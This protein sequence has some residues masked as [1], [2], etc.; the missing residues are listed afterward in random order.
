[1]KKMQFSGLLLSMLTT[2]ACSHYALADTANSVA[3]QSGGTTQTAG[4]P[5]TFVGLCGVAGDG[6]GARYTVDTLGNEWRTQYSEGWIYGPTKIPVIEPSTITSLACNLADVQYA[7]ASDS[8]GAVYVAYGNTYYDHWNQ[9]GKPSG[10]PITAIAAATGAK[11]IYVGDKNGNVYSTEAGNPSAKWQLNG[12]FSGKEGIT[13]MAI[14]GVVTGGQVPYLLVAANNINSY[15]VFELP[16]DTS[17]RWSATTGAS[18]PAFTLLA[19][20]VGSPYAY[21]SD[22]SSRTWVYNLSK[23]FASWTELP[24]LR[25]TQISA[26]FSTFDNQYVYLADKSGNTWVRNNDGK[27]EAWTALPQIPSKLAVIGITATSW[28]MV[29][30]INGNTYRRKEGDTT[31]A[32]E[33][34]GTPSITPSQTSGNH[35]RQ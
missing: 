29:E 5:D 16:T 26:M 21:G 8:S 17:N 10:E 27:T 12:V 22:G 9:F 18:L 34:I 15:T 19:A 3:P 13:A 20:S 25:D 14:G 30:D 31:S 2:L 35:A 23:A 6:Y 32:W 4:T 7:Y 11:N 33:Y 28:V 24:E 1:M